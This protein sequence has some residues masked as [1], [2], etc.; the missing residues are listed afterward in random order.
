MSV[1]TRFGEVTIISQDD[2]VPEG[3][4]TLKYDEGSEI[5]D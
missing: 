4:R 3:W 2:E 5:K 1:S